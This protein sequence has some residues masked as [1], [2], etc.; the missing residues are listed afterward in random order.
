M[1]LTPDP[2][3]PPCSPG[4]GEGRQGSDSYWAFCIDHLGTPQ[5]A[6][7]TSRNAKQRGKDYREI[8]NPDDFT[9]FAKLRD[10]RNDIGQTAGVPVYAVFTNE[11]WR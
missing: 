10:P 2:Q 1:H 11:P 4:T 7:D 9:V 8:L 6:T 5:G 3:V